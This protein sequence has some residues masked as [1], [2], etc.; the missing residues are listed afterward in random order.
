MFQF[1]VQ[2]DRQDKNAVGWNERDELSKHESQQGSFFILL[3]Y[4]CFLVLPKLK[5]LVKHRFT[6]P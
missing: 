1:G 5:L 6:K 3:P 2:S 4:N